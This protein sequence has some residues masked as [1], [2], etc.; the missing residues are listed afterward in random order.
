VA[1]L[2][3]SEEVS[4]LHSVR[5]KQEYIER[6]GKNFYTPSFLKEQIKFKEIPWTLEEQK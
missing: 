1:A 2:K 6:S 3:N 4:S 5:N